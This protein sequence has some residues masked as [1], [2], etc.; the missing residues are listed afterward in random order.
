[1]KQNWK[2]SVGYSGWESRPIGILSKSARLS[3]A[4]KGSNLMARCVSYGPPS[5]PS[6]PSY[7]SCQLDYLF[8][9]QVA[10][11][12]WPESLWRDL[13][14]MH[15]LSV[16]P[17]VPGSTNPSVIKSTLLTSELFGSPRHPSDWHSK[18][19]RGSLPTLVSSIGKSCSAMPLT[20]KG[21]MSTGFT[22]LHMIFWNSHG[23]RYG[24]HAVIGAAFSHFTF[25]LSKGV[26]VADPLK[27]L[28][29]AGW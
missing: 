28:S 23:P 17:W 20:K 6:S 4:F 2:V 12:M 16:N 9:S 14:E 5:S 22:Y 15:Q 21:S 7:S 26:L 8:W 3:K 24:A 10:S 25:E 29:H 18:I 11:N 27:K 1:M 19:C 13:G